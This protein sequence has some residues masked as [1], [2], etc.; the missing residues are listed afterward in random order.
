MKRIH[1][2]AT[3]RRAHQLSAAPSRALSPD[4]VALLAERPHDRESLLTGLGVGLRTFYRELDMLRRCGIKV[5][6]ADRAYN[7]KTTA[8]DAQGRL[9]FPDPQ[10]SFAEMVGTRPTPGRGRPP[11]QRDCSSS[12]IS[13]PPSEAVKTGKKKGP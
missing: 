11:A 3:A 5:Q 7:L 9:P 8:E 1:R 13:P 4:Y 10:F 12:V 6:R 2:P